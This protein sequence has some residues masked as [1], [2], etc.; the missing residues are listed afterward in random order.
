MNL[1]RH[2]FQYHDLSTLK[3]NRDVDTYNIHN[4]KCIKYTVQMLHSANMLESC[5]FALKA[6]NIAQIKEAIVEGFIP[7]LLVLSR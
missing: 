5:M 4:T 3:V 2:H 7:I 6:V 1:L